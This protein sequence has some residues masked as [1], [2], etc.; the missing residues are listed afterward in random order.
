MDDMKDINTA[1]PEA[2]AVSEKK[3]I[4]AEIFDMSVRENVESEPPKK[5]NWFKELY[6]WAQAIAVAMVLALLI[7]QFL[8]A[9]V[10][11]EGSSMLPTLQS[12]ERLVVTKLFYKPKEKDIVVVKSREL[13]K[14]I[15]KR[16]IAV[17]G[18]VLDIRP[19]TGNV[20]VNGEVLDE[21]YILEKL[22]SGGSANAY[23]LTVPEGYVFVMGDNRNNSQ[24]SRNLGLV[25]YEDVVGRASLRIA[26]F[27]RFGGLYENLE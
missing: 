6:E 10:Q 8:F 23:P 9:L 3:C 22:R 25:A 5:N 14:F 26:P 19:E 7:N 11:V 21:P 4:D 17:P 1:T 15:I 13:G 18:D 27:S 16:V 12:K 24:D 20:I 2:P